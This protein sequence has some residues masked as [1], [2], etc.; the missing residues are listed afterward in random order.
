MRVRREIIYE[1][2]SDWIEKTLKRSIL[3]KRGNKFVTPFGSIKLVSEVRGEENGSIK[4][5]R[6]GNKKQETGEGLGGGSVACLG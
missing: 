2:E 6:K 5:S 4:G 3:K 1:G